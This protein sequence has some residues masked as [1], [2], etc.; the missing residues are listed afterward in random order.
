MTRILVADDEETFLYATA[1]LL[2]LEGYD[3]DCVRDGLSAIAK[4]Q[5]HSY[6]LIISDIKMP[7]NPNLELVRAL[8]QLAP[9]VPVIL[10]TG[11]P[12][13]RSAVQSIQLPVVAY[14]T[15]PLDFDELLQQIRTALAQVEADGTLRMLKQQLQEWSRN[16]EALERSLPL[17]RRGAIATE[18]TKLP[19]RY[20]EGVH[21]KSAIDVTP[22]QLRALR[23]IRGLSAREWEIVQRLWSHQTVDSIS[24]S[25]FVSKHT[26]RNHLKAIFRKIGVHSQSALLEW[27][28]QK[29]AEQRAAH[30]KS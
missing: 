30:E 23:E 13:L 18:I 17:K 10:V 15:K 25:L 29:A 8:P 5:E 22:D 1:D 26:I 27:L 16:L 19:F 24:K 11:Y 20:S 3:C 28:T 6:A 12:T 4:L 21:A 7:G 14:L 9:G 2:R